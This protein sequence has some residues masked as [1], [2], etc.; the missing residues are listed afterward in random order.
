MA[1]KKENIK[2]QKNIIK[3]RKEKKKPIST[4]SSKNK[5]K[6]KKSE[7]KYSKKY[8]EVVKL[9]ER[10]KKYSLDEALELIK[11]TSVTKFDSSVEIN[12]RLGVNLK[13]S[14]QIVRDTIT[15]PHSTGKVKKVAVVAQ[16]DKQEEAKESGA[17]FVGAEDLI[18]DIEKSKINFDILVAT[19][20]VMGKLGKL[21]KI[22][23]PKGLMPN[24]KTGTVT[25]DIKGV[26]KDI[27]KGMLEFRMDSTGIVHASFGKV[28]F[29][30]Q[31]L[32]ENF[33]AFFEAI[34][35]A[36]PKGVKGVYI[37]G[38]SLASTMGP[39]IKLDLSRLK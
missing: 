32:K 11:K 21:G 24:P 33:L 2:Q 36:K 5:N 15:L 18:N 19:P 4:K 10:D 3:P 6:L 20:D 13:D 8:R 35:K 31:K 28:S 39:G 9:I 38:I 1:K 34:N 29:D 22:L 26:I 14:S 27:K 23:G 17:D 37:R 12:V 30:T 16:G 25:Q 7:K